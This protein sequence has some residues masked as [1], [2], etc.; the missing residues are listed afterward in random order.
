M[1]TEDSQQTMKGEM[2]PS[3]GPNT[4]VAKLPQPGIQ[5]GGGGES[6]G[7]GLENT[8][9]QRKWDTKVCLVINPPPSWAAL[10]HAV[11]TY[12]VHNTLR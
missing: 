7:K 4:N 3:M 9:G 5:V 6:T 8:V 11:G 12:I 1:S 10:P 2:Q